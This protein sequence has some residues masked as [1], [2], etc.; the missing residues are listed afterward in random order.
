[1][2]GAAVSLSP[3]DVLKILWVLYCVAWLP[4][5]SCQLL[6][7]LGVLWKLFLFD[8]LLKCIS[9]ACSLS[10]VVK[11]PC[12]LLYAIETVWHW[13][14][15]YLLVSRACD[16]PYEILLVSLAVTMHFI[17]FLAGFVVYVAKKLN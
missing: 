14:G 5:E 16:H 8:V 15:F 10:E 11:G 1:M 2:K 4:T 12:L 13:Y 7:W 17:S 6:N 3:A 9:V